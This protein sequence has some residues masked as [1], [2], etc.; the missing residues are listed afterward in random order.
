RGLAVL[1]R[2]DSGREDLEE[3]RDHRRPSLR[4]ALRAN[5]RRGRGLEEH[6]ADPRASAP[7][8]GGLRRASL[9]ARRYFRRAILEEAG[10]GNGERERRVTDTHS[11]P[12]A[13]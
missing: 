10:G 3:R 13:A 12:S 1:A 11:T 6:L 4:E 7:V 2:Q 5:V 8:R 9:P